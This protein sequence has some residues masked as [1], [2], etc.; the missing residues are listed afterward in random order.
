MEDISG[1]F[2]KF[3]RYSVLN[4][5]QNV[6]LSSNFNRASIVLIQARGNNAD[7][8]FIFKGK[9]TITKTRISKTFLWNQWHVIPCLKI[10]FKNADRQSSNNYSH[11]KVKSHSIVMHS[12]SKNC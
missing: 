11:L 10:V 2:G 6:Y 4:I 12:K 3:R 9:V 1:L 5:R 8:H 7:P